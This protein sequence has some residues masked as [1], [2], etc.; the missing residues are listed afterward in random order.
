MSNLFGQLAV[1]IRQSRVVGEIAAGLVLGPTVL[2]SAFPHISGLLFSSQSIDIL[3]ALSELGLLLLI[4]EIPWHMPESKRANIS[5]FGPVVVSVLGALASFGLGCM[6]GAYSKEEIAPEQSFWPY[7]LFCGI[8][9][10]VTAL[11][12]LVRIVRDN[13]ISGDVGQMALSSA[14]YTEI[15][16]CLGLAIVFAI[17]LSD[18]ESSVNSVVRFMGFILFVVFSLYIIR[19]LIKAKL[20]SYLN[21]GERT[22]VSFAFVYC[23]VSAQITALLGFHQV[24][25]AI[26]AAYI[27][28]STSGMQVI[29][30]KWIGRFG[31]LILS[32]IFFAYSGIQ[33]S[34]GAFGDLNLW[35]WLAIFVVG[36]LFGKI[37]GSYAGGR[38]MGLDAASSLELGVLMNTKGLIE[39]VV[40]GI[41]LE[42]GILSSSAYSVLL[43]LALISTALTVPLV[44][45]LHKKEGKASEN[46]SSASKTDL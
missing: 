27:F 2:G 7:V 8:V 26:L 14:L 11:P 21:F 39:L 23:L 5:G 30:R 22:R 43:L 41:G 34:L 20:F 12:V 45:L 40:L 35:M 19:P 28:S 25:G 42:M 36:G 37:A 13:N 17:Q 18:V 46:Y 3:K 15:F 9:L 10:S 32:P 6:I 33:V 31:D 29:W 24:I 4:F 38:L 44:G 1:K 16:T